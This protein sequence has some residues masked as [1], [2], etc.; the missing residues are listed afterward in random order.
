MMRLARC[1][2]PAV[3]LAA[4]AS[5]PEG[6]YGKPYAIFQPDTKVIRPTGEAPAYVI[7]IDDRTIPRGRFDP[8]EAGMRNVEVALTVAQD[9][10]VQKTYP[11]RVD[12]K[13]CM[14]YYMSLQQA[15]PGAEWTPYVSGIDRIGECA[16]RFDIRY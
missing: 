16:S 4:C 5:T 9:S 10:T 14:R 7:K 13:P 12:A 2:A 3:L 15:S 8:V 11:I 6:Q 1:I